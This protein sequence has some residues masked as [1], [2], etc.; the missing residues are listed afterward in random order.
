[1]FCQKQDALRDAAGHN[2]SRG[3]AM[4]TNL[5]ALAVASALMLTQASVYAVEPVDPA[6]APQVVPSASVS[7]PDSAEPTE[8]TSDAA[9]ADTATAVAEVAVSAAATEGAASA[10]PTEVTTD[11]DAATAAGAVG[12]AEAG[13]GL[14]ADAVPQFED[15]QPPAGDKVEPLPQGL[16]FLMAE[17]QRGSVDAQVLL[18]RSLEVGP[19]K[20]LKAAFHWWQQAAIAHDPR[21]ELEL[22]HYFAQGRVVDQD[23][24]QSLYWLERSALGG[25][26][27][28]QLLLAMNYKA[29]QCCPQNAQLAA[30]W[31]EQA[32]V[33]GS[34]VA[35]AQI[36]YCYERGIG[37]PVDRQKAFYWHQF[38]GTHCGPSL[39]RG[40]RR[41]L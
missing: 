5:L 10:A 32:A 11:V 15:P 29:G 31:F 9:R 21:A 39:K 36:A 33:S 24:K 26:A 38:A 35:Q 2:L 1:M 37:V 8:A 13:T 22:S 14:F 28:A 7:A 19:Q 3:G 12:A 16:V 40:V 41:Q 23:L 30:Y 17:A 4:R 34:G 27:S 18:A 6:A 20:D 25:N